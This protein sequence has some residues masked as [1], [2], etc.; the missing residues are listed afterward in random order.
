MLKSGQIIDDKYKILS[1]VGQ[2]GMSTVYKA[3]NI[4]LGNYWAVK[5][6]I[7]KDILEKEVLI[8]G[9]L[10]HQGL[11][12]IVDVIKLD[13]QWYLIEEFIEG[14]PL[15]DIVNMSDPVKNDIIINWALQLC[16]ILKY[17]HSQ[18]PNP[19]IYQDMKPSNV[20]IGHDG[21][22]K[23]VD[24]GIS[25]LRDNQYEKSGLGTKGYAAP[26]Q[27]KQSTEK[28]DKRTDI[29]GLG[30]TL[31]HLVTQIKPKGVYSHDIKLLKS[32]KDYK[33]LKNII[34]KSI[35]PNPNSRYQDI[36]LLIDELKNINKLAKDVK[37]HKKTFLTKKFFK[38]LKF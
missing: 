27:Y 26:E 33:E 28:I 3:V 34:N 16:Q 20:I 12:M 24:F 19:I 4:R 8:L 1:V 25:A 15:S 23:L 21:I 30:A 31:Y 17:L 10:K 9:K 14:I 6:F 37:N 5:E 35:E 18:N 22:V 36:S 2:G 32:I 7:R 11:P 38:K 29:Y 13:K